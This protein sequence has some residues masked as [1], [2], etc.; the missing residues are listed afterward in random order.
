MRIK[1]KKFKPID[2]FDD[3]LK[4]VRTGDLAITTRDDAPGV[5]ITWF[6]QSTLQHTAVFVW[7]NKDKYM[8]N[9][10][11]EIVADS[12]NES[13]LTLMH[14]T[15]RRMFDIWSRSVKNGL[16]LCSLD[17]YAH[18]NL[19]AIFNRPLTRLIS[20]EEAVIKIHA[21]LE[22]RCN[23]LMYESDLRTILG[24][25]LGLPFCPWENRKICTA[26]IYDYME[27][28]FNFPL[29]Q[30]AYISNKEEFDFPQRDPNVFRAIDFTY[31]SNKSPVL[32]SE[33]EH[34][35]YGVTPGSHLG[36]WHP[37]N[38]F[39]IIGFIIMI[40]I[41]LIVAMIHGRDSPK[42]YKKL[43]H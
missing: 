7:I 27:K 14:I 24:V 23:D 22:M 5:F 35:V 12:S 13:V 9:D 41:I 36:I 25:P 19:I 34:L 43:H 8:N 4:S 31:T 30:G 38:V 18:N 42:I 6:T 40:F 11:V 3:R 17:E 16:V 15:K 26:M 21:Y 2:H 10:R 37:W 33:E 1:P 29:G 32:S 20:S 28:S 39:M